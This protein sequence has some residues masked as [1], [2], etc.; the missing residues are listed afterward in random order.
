MIKRGVEAKDSASWL[1]GAGGLLDRL[2]S[3]LLG[4]AVALLL[5]PSG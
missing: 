2:D 3:L 4:L 1:A 5:A